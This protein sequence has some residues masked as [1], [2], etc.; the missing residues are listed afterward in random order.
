[1]RFE[2]AALGECG[3]SVDGRW[4][5]VG[6]VEEVVARKFVVGRRR[7][8]SSSSSG[9]GSAR[10]QHLHHKQRPM[11]KGVILR[12]VGLPRSPVGIQ[13]GEWVG[14]RQGG[15]STTYEV[16]VT[17]D[18]VVSDLDA[19]R[20]AE[21]AKRRRLTRS[22]A[23]IAPL[24]RAAETGTETGVTAT[25]RFT[26]PALRSYGVGHG[27]VGRRPVGGQG[28]SS[29][30]GPR[31]VTFHGVRGS[32]PCQGVEV[33]CSAATRRASRSH[34]GEQP[35]VFDLGTGL[36]Y[37]AD[38]RPAVAFHGTALLSHLHWDHVQGLPFFHPLLRAGAQLQVHAP[39]QTDGSHPAEVMKR[40]LQPPF[41][42]VTLDE[43]AGD[44]EIHDA[45]PEFSVGGYRVITADVPHNGPT[46]GY[47][48]ELGRASIVYVPDH[49]QDLGGGIADG[50]VELCRGADLLIHDAQ[51]TSE[52]L[53][54]KA[55]WGHCTPEY[56]VDVA[57]AAG[58]KGLAL[59]HR[60]GAGDRQVGRWQ[61]RRRR[62]PAASGLRRLRGMSV[63]LAVEPCAQGDVIARASTACSRSGALLLHSHWHG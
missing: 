32:T 3:V 20:R 23:A 13:A 56:A 34:P 50:V 46:L 30:L 45:K 5:S 48:V 37:F 15:V 39:T 62:R 57:V 44:V 27:A 28:S 59:F 9:G 54:M 8:R 16:R 61:P 63:E 47:R 18:G 41:F 58:V 43:I 12:P 26:T 52:D 6:T 49:Q 24:S 25:A 2:G 17:D 4:T 36:R 31:Y 33:R 40:V 60:S 51:Y 22:V 55:T 38:A 29:S 14:G 35:L 10:W 42:P 19:S 21:V 1:M 7:T 53:A 11:L